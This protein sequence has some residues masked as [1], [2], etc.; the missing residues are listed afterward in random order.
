M[1]F[2]L[3]SQAQ[4]ALMII[5][6]GFYLFV[7]WLPSSNGLMQAWPFVLLWQLGLGVVAL[8]AIGQ[9]LSGQTPRFYRLGKRWDS[10]VLGGLILL[11]INMVVARFP[12]LA[13]WQAW[14]VMVSVMAFY[15]LHH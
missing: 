4:K 14:R 9:V 5:T 2:A 1:M 15:G 12:Q 11:V 3:F 10:W 6:L 13:L 8:W 7:S